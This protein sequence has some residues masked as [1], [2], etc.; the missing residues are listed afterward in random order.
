MF[1]SISSTISSFISGL[2]ILS[3]ILVP[4]LIYNKLW[5][6]SAIVVLNSF[7]AFYISK[8]MRP[9]HFVKY[10]NQ[11]SKMYFE[12]SALMSVYDKIN[13]NYKNDQI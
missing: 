11:F 5:I 9:M 4:W 6:P 2:Q 7:L 13:N 12:K 3:V 10:A 8:K 1:P